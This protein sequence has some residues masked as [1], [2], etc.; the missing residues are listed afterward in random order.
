MKALL[1]YLR[2]M[3]PHLNWVLSGALLGLVTLIASIGLLSLSGWFITA[4]ALA[5][6]A[7]LAQPFNFFTPG[8]G[9]RGFAILRTAGRYGE[10][11]VS[12]EATFRLIT[13]LRT[14]F[15]RH[16]EPL[17]AGQLSRLGSAQ[18]LSRLIADI[19]ALD[20]LY[21]R[22]LA[23]TGI[24]LMVLLLMAFFLGLFQPQV[25]LI[26]VAGL[27]VAGFLLPW[28]GYRLGQGPGSLQPRALSELRVALVALVPGDGGVA[29][30][31][32]TGSSAAAGA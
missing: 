1:P 17:G 8:A 16:L 5:G 27:L 6:L 21:L 32:W 3:R 7:S 28:L 22:V 20:N 25:A 2:Q 9:V 31:R 11:V 4:T 19:D 13:R 24:A 26:A 12:H 15:Y 23:P 18:L 30:L 14:W 29:Y 10:R